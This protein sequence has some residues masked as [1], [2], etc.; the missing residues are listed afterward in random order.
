MKKFIVLS[1]FLTLI[2][3]TTSARVTHIADWSGSLPGEEPKTETSCSQL[4]EG[5]SLTTLICPDNEKLI[6]CPAQDCDYYHKC[7]AE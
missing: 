7:V 2:A 3:G 1:V 6:D 4:C 5:Y